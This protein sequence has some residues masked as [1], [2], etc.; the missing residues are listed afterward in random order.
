MQ[1]LSSLYLV[2]P[3]A[4]ELCIAKSTIDRLLKDVE[5]KDPATMLK[6]LYNYKKTFPETFQLA[7][8]VVTLGCSTAVCE[9]TFT[10]LARIDAPERRSMTPE[11]KGSLALLAFESKRT[12]NIDMWN[13]LK[14]FAAKQRRLQLF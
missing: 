1:P 14:K 11:R 9:S 6:I 7:A 12:D 10:T 4:E 8:S 5:I 2:V 13:F 3:S